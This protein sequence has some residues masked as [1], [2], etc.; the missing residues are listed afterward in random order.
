MNWLINGRVL[1]SLTGGG[2]CRAKEEIRPKLQGQRLSFPYLITS[3]SGMDENTCYD[4]TDTHYAKDCP[5]N[6]GEL[7]E[8]ITGQPDGKDG[9]T[10][11]T[12][13]FSDKFASGR[14]YNYHQNKFSIRKAYCQG[15]NRVISAGKTSS[16]AI[17]LGSG[18][19]VWFA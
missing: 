4:K 11:V 6:R 14:I 19:V 13:K 10:Q 18:G 5:D 16:L 8:E 7:F 3:F 2:L 9:F 12:D 17:A 15:E 1:F